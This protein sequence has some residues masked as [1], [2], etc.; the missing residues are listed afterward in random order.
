MRY[1]TEQV[2]DNYELEVIVDAGYCL[3]S[4]GHEIKSERLYHR[5]LFCKVRLPLGIN[6]LLKSRQ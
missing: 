4:K 5:N 3:N 2:C 6:L 1:C